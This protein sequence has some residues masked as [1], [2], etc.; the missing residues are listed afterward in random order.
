[1]P[2]QEERRSETRAALLEAGATLF[3]ERGIAGASVDA[4]ASAAGRTSGALYDHFGSKEGLL[5]ALLETWVGDASV[6]IAAE[7]AAAATFDEWV[8]AMWHAVARP[9]SGDGRWIAL[10]HELWS[11][12]AQSPDATR[13]LAKRYQAAWAG[14]EQHAAAFADVPPGTGAT[15]VGLLF[16]LEM[17]RRV[18]PA[19]VTDE[20]AVT[21]LT[22]VL[23][24]HDRTTT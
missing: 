10:E 12:A 11:Y 14:I 9:P 15:V 4:I 1:M 7:Q 13:Y 17:M 20:V 3:A 19:A 23:T 2:T 8:A 18:D 5:F 22:S 21:A 6:A 24:A 16:G